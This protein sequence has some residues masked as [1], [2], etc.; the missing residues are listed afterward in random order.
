MTENVSDCMQSWPEGGASEESWGRCG[1][2]CRS[3][4]SFFSSF[5]FKCYIKPSW[6]SVKMISLKNERGLVI[7]VVWLGKKSVWMSCWFYDK[8]LESFE[9]ILICQPMSSLIWNPS[10]F[11]SGHLYHISSWFQLTCSAWPNTHDLWSDESLG[12]RY[13]HGFRQKVWLITV[14]ELKALELETRAFVVS[15][16]HVYLTECYLWYHNLWE[17][18]HCVML[19]LVPLCF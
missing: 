14:S 18:T 11:Q 17:L 2:C 7:N 19:L 13:L 1:S 5:F 4:I 6:T 9:D 3:M 8:S 15:G 16:D 10:S 12:D